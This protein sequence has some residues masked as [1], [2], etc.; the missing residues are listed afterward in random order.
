[1]WFVIEDS[2]RT[3]FAKFVEAGL[4]DK[5]LTVWNRDT[6]D[7]GIPIALEYCG[8]DWRGKVD[9]ESFTLIELE[10]V[11]ICYLV[12]CSEPSGRSAIS[13]S[14]LPTDVTITLTACSWPSRDPA[15]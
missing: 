3:M 13:T 12:V 4:E 7:L 15:R 2:G 9:S 1:M 6:K 14:P 10:I 5:Y 11:L 8:V